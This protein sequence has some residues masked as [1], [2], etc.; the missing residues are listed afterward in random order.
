MRRRMARVSQRL[1]LFAATGLSW[2]ATIPPPDVDSLIQQSVRTIEAD[3]NQAPNYSFVERDV[4]SKK[5]SLPTVKTYEV[6]MIDGS[7]YNHL[8]AVD[9]KPLSAGEQAEEER[10]LRF[11]I[12]K[13]Q[14]ESYRE[15]YKRTE[16]YEKERHEDRAILLGMVDAFN[17]QLAGEESL[18]GHDCWVLDAEP[19][20]GYEPTNR[21]T[22][23]L[24]G[25]KG[26]LWIDKA[27]DQWVKVQAEVFKPVSFFGF[28]A[29][30]GP[31][32]RFMLEQE[33]VGQNLWLPKH[34]SM[35]VNASALGFINEDSVDD[36]TYRD[37]KPM[38]QTS[39][40]LQTASH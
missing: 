37:Y 28:F 39:A 20:H 10:K 5:Q 15:R 18:D 9:D 25:M 26:R 4:E 38:S 8:I 34:F 40:A 14:N 19:R 24:K 22:K 3:W 11:E 30:V 17:F 21:E 6:V 23:V 32:T 29:K 31:G 7:P 13:R 1:L 16:K 33:P 2:A 27:T 12:A 35:K 36:E